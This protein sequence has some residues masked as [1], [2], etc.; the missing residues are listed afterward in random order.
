[1]NQAKPNSEPKN[2]F[3]EPREIITYRNSRM[4]ELRRGGKK[5]VLSY[6]IIRECSTLSEHLSTLRSYSVLNERIGGKTFKVA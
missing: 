5:I 2:C 1:M 6:G 3:Q 4:H